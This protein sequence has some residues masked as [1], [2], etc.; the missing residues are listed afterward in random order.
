MIDQ[1]DLRIDSVTSKKYYYYKRWVW[2][3]FPLFCLS[4]QKY[5]FSN[6]MSYCYQEEKNYLDF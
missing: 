6:L 1:L 2:M 4:S 5:S 3:N